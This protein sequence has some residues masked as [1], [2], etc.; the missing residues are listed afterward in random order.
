M[1]KYS[2]YSYSKMSTYSSCPLKFKF[3]YIDRLR[4]DK[5]VKALEKGSFFH[6]LCE[7]YVIGKGRDSKY[8]IDSDI[9]EETQKIFNDGINSDSYLNRYL[10]YLKCL[11]PV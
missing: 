11:F 3:N 9:E 8:I 7:Q 4:I 2:P 10:N 6:H 5:K 1:S